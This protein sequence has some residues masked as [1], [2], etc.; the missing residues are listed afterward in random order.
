MRYA[1]VLTLVSLVLA[2]VRRLL[3]AAEVPG[4]L[5]VVDCQ[6]RYVPPGGELN[7][8]AW[9]VLEARRKGW[10]IIF[11]EYYTAEPTHELLTSMVR[12]YEWRCETK[13]KLT[14]GGG[15]VVVDVCRELGWDSS[16]FRLIGALTYCCVA[17]TAAE[18]NDELPESEIEVV[19][20]ACYDTEETGSFRSHAKI[21]WVN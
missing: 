9:E 1:V 7:R 3:P 20:G 11:L 21:R 17:L 10:R 19:A 4:V 2:V 16:K 12:G 14:Y 6:P 8:M 13:R 18:I 15:T 5:V